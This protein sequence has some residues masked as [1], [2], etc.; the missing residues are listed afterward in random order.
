MKTEIKQIY[1]HFGKGNQIDKTIE[2]LEELKVELIESKIYIN[3]AEKSSYD[4]N[5]IYAK[6]AL[7]KKKANITQE[8]ADVVI[9]I[10]QMQLAFNISDDELSEQMEFKIKRT[11]DRIKEGYYDNK[12]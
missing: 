9:M 6:N 10:H 11:F 1:E 7:E 8:M 2:E 5:V 3:L 12:R 4:E